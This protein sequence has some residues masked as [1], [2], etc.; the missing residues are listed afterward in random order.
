MATS[1]PVFS[2][3]MRR[4]LEAMVAG[5]AIP[6]DAHAALSDEERQEVA[7]LARTAHLTRIT[8]HQP[9]PTQ[10]MEARALARAQATLAARPA[11]ASGRGGADAPAPAA[12]SGG[13]PAGYDA[14]EDESFFRWLGRLFGKRR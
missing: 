8:L 10:E 13:S 2:E 5:E 1:E 14:P 3:P 11:G 6:P 7:A 12:S 4:V 9:E